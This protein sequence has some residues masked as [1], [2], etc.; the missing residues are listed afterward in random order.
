M[1]KTGAN[2][3]FPT[4]SG[5]SGRKLEDGPSKFCPRSAPT[6]NHSATTRAY[7][8]IM[9]LVR[10]LRRCAIAGVLLL[11]VFPTVAQE[12]TMNGVARSASLFNALKEFCSEQFPVNAEKAQKYV[13]MYFD[14]GVKSFGEKKF[15]TEL[16]EEYAR[17]KKEVE[18]TRPTQWCAYQ[19][20]RLQRDD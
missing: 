12:I 1:Q 3:S 16:V 18:I 20:E 14:V 13:R 4:L 15:R 19:R 7:D 10:V 9:P 17:R 8:F 11:Q 5:H 2:D 6:M